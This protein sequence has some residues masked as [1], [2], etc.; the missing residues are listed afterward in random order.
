MKG[1]C[2]VD[3]KNDLRRMNDIAVTAREKVISAHLGS[4]PSSFG[5]CKRASIASI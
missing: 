1:A 4:L 5:V 3:G 2:N